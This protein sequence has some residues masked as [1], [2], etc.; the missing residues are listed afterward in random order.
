M[1]FE[2]NTEVFV[3][4]GLHDNVLPHWY[5]A[6]FHRDKA[7]RESNN[8]SELIRHP[9]KE[10]TARHWVIATRDFQQLSIAVSDVIKAEMEDAFSH[11]PM[12]A[13]MALLETLG[14]I[15]ED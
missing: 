10:E 13:I 7:H 11:N 6:E 2:G 9:S 3:N 1:Q 4:L 14:E 5:E 15:M 8:M 12:A